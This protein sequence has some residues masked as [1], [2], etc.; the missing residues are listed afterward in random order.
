VGVA[1]WAV[2]AAGTIGSP[3]AFRIRL[4]GDK[5]ELAADDESTSPAAP[6]AP[7]RNISRR[8][9]DTLA[10]RFRNVVSIIQWVNGR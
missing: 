1:I 4:T 10:L 2:G 6:M 9:K 3:L 7:K 5:L 8:F